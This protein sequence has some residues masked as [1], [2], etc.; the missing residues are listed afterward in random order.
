M[1]ERVKEEGEGRGGVWV[2]EKGDSDGW[3]GRSKGKGKKGVASPWPWGKKEPPPDEF[4]SQGRGLN[5]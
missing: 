4:I 2:C 1:R 3:A 5:I